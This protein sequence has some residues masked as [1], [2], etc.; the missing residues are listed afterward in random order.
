MRRRPDEIFELVRGKSVLHVGC[1]DHLEII[2]IKLQSNNLLHQQL[3]C[4][5]S[6][7]LGIDIDEKAAGYL[8]ARG[9]ENILIADITQPGIS[10]IA[11][12]RWDYLLLA[13]ILEHIDDPVSFLK[14]I[15]VH[16]KNNI[17]GVIITAPNAFG[18]IHM[19][20][21]LGDGIESVNRD[22]RYW[23]TPYTLC[24]VA[25]RAG[26]IPDNIIMC[27][28]EYAE[29]SEAFREVLLDKPILMDTIILEAH[30]L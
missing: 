23:F 10:Q 14:A 2:E 15:A 22:H 4:V 5:A 17:G 24:K 27:A 9:F 26:L 19:S 1:T 25:Y 11:A 13:D 7:C 6:A 28:N 8:R 12:A 30:W 16:Y 18:L 20:A 29:I 3:S 21:A